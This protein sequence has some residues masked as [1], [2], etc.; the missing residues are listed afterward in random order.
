MDGGTEAAARMAWRRLAAATMTAAAA[1]A[2]SL[3]LRASWRRGGLS[4]DDFGV[5]LLAFYFALPA[6]AIL[7]L[8]LFLILRA[9]RWVR[10]WSC[11]SAGALGGASVVMFV[12]GASA[13]QARDLPVW[14]AVGI[15]AALAFWMTVREKPALARA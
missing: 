14:C 9:L 11:A 5:A 15:V 12:S 2:V 1:V 7:G 6:V 8:P 3:M 10:W 4:L 13:W